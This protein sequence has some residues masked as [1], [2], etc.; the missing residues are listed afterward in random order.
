MTTP[1]LNDLLQALYDGQHV[2]ASRGI[3]AAQL[4]A[5][6]DCGPRHLRDLVTAARMDGIGLCGTPRDG[7]F[8]AGRA[9][10]IEETCRFLR[11]RAM[12]TLTLES[13]LRRM[14]LPDLLGQLRL[15]T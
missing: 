2:G 1:T 10:E 15:P 6:M 12:Q 14:P 5:R 3:C 4:A 7:Y 13:R 9:E 11:S 8:I